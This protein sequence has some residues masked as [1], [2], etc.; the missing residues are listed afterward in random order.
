MIYFNK[1]D[2]VFETK[3][4]Q[5]PGGQHRNRTASCVVATHVPT[6]ISVTIDE[7]NQ[8]NNKRKALRLLEQKVKDYFE[9]EKA[10]V[11]KNLRDHRIKNT[12][13]IRTYDYKAGTVK[14]HRTGKVASLK[15]VMEKGKIELLR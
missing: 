15:D 4:G 9:E 3:V 1:K 6:S 11:R 12:K 13:R 2:V 8:H 7:R 14:D 10:S 5:G